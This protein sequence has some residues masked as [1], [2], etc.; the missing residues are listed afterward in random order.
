[1]RVLPPHRAVERRHRHRGCRSWT[2]DWSWF[3]G[4]GRASAATSSRLA[5]RARRMKKPR[6]AIAAGITTRHP[7]VQPDDASRRTASQASSGRCWRRARGRGR[8][9]LRRLSRPS[10]RP[11]R[12]QSAPSPPTASWRSPTA[13]SAAGLPARRDGRAWED[14]RSWRDP[15]S[16]GLLEDGTLC[17]G[18]IIT[19]DRAFR[20]LARAGIHAGRSQPHVQR[21]PGRRAGAGRAGRH[22]PRRAGRP[23]RAR[24]P[25][26]R[27]HDATSAACPPGPG[28]VQR[29]E[30][31]EPPS[32]AG[33][34]DQ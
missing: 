21:H 1:M 23:G 4:F 28:P 9:H 30:P 3:G 8:A 32:C 14:V 11:C 6:A 18:S 17:G 25:A 15:Q 12:W 24:S 22:R 27:G 16:A 7:P 33:R 10:R 34:L 29:Y 13:P 26:R 19:M 20:T 31:R 5:T 2:A